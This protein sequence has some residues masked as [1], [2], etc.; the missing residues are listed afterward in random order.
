MLCEVSRAVTRLAANLMEKWPRTNLEG[1]A[2][3]EPPP[4]RVK[5]PRPE[6]LWNW[7]GKFW[8]CYHCLRCKR[9]KD[10]PPPGCCS[11]TL[12]VDPAELRALEHNCMVVDFSDGGFAA[13]CMRCHA[14]TTGGQMRRLAKQCIGK[15]PIRSEVFSRL[16]R[17][18]HPDHKRVGVTAE[19]EEVAL[20]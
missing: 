19:L 10:K 4:P 18:L 13:V 8:Q 11:R 9:S 20:I 1:V 6:H 7:V 3:V 14:F 17:G 5:D 12:R 2:R 16:G 15:P